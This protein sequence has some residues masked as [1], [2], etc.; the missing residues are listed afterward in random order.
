MEQM[1][2]RSKTVRLA[3]IALRTSQYKVKCPCMRESRV[4]QKVVN[5]AT[6]IQLATTVKARL[7]RSRF[8]QH[9]SNVRKRFRAMR[10]EQKVAQRGFRRLAKHS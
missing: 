8:P 2:G 6:G 1:P 5:I 10:I 4:R 9:V 7:R 3:A